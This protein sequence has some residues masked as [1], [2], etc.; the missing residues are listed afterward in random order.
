MLFLRIFR[1][2]NVQK[3]HIFRGK[4]TEMEKQLRMSR[5]Q[6]RDRFP[7]MRNPFQGS[8]LPFSWKKVLKK[9]INVVFYCI[10]QL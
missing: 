2:F 10:I 8:S 5:K 1:G 4:G 6:K 7:L 9:Y 3:Q